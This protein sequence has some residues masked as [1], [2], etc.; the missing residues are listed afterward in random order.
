MKLSSR[1]FLIALT[2]I[3]SIITH[4]AIA[5]TPKKETGFSIENIDTSVKPQDN[6]YRFAN[7]NWLKNAVIPDD[8]V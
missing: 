5:D 8:N 4:N 7:G 2:F 3:S 1:L 6:F